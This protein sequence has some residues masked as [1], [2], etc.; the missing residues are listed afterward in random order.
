LIAGLPG[1]GYVG[2]LAVDYLIR[3]LNAEPICYIYSGTFPAQIEVTESGV[4]TPLKG[5]IY[6]WE[7]VD[8]HPNLLLFTANV[9]PQSSEGSYKMAKFVLDFAKKRGVTHVYTLAAYLTDQ[10]VGENPGIYV[11]VTHPDVL[12]LFTRPVRPLTDGVITGL[13]GL[14][15]GIAKLFD[16]KGAC[17]M[18]ETIGMYL[19]YIAAKAV[20][21]TL[22]GVI[23][24]E[25]D[26]SLLKR[27]G[28]PML[29]ILMRQEE[30]LRRFRKRGDR[31]DETPTYIG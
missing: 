21:D 14:L 17:I 22:L 1:I 11:A 6:F 20:L 28:E 2:K 10:I 5:T 31:R 23:R 12:N 15:V 29:K 4:V 27:K 25:L 26:T 3:T 8:T 7:S 16:M 18:G 9:Q 24:M 13:N 19:D 30:E